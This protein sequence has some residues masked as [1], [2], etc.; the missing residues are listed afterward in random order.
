MTGGMPY[1]EREKKYI[2]ANGE[3]MIRAQ[4]AT[5]LNEMYPEDNNGKR[6]KY[7]VRAFL[8]KRKYNL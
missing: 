7:G 5:D 4:I 3:I 8:Y 2:V 6:T 1:T